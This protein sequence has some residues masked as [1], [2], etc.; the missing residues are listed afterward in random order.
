MKASKIIL[1]GVLGTTFMTLYSYMISRK[2]K[3]QYVEPVLLNKLIDGSENLPDIENEETHPAGWLAHY[4]IGILF[5]VAYWVIWRR[6]LQSP[7]PIR[8]LIIGALS[9]IVAIVAWKTM[10]A[11]NANPPHNNRIGYFRQL[12]YAHL[13]FSALALTGYKLPDYIR[14]SRTK[15]LTPSS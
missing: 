9:G 2:E 10:F 3:Q 7:G 12:F 13:I 5:I 14:Q 11:A 6:A 8:T 1:A 15:F 4:G